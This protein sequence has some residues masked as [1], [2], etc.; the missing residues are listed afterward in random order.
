VPAC[1]ACCLAFAVLALHGF[2]E[3]PG[4]V[5]YL[6]YLLYWTRPEYAKYL[7]YPHSLVFLNLLQ[8]ETYRTRVSTVQYIDRRPPARPPAC[9]PSVANLRG[10]WVI[11]VAWYR[12][13]ATLSLCSR[14]N[15]NSSGTGCTGLTASPRYSRTL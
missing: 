2:Y 4:F 8:D 6:E 15:G 7:M 1:W 9:L 3:K 12:S 13:C 11:C 5:H 14:A 10:A